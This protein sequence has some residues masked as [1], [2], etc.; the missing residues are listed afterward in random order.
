MRAITTQVTRTPPEADRTRRR[1]RQRTHLRTGEERAAGWLNPDNMSEDCR[2][3]DGKSALQA[4]P[5]L[6]SAAKMGRDGTGEAERSSR[7]RRRST[8]GGGLVEG[9]VESGGTTRVRLDGA[10]GAH[11]DHRVGT[12]Q[13]RLDGAQGAHRAYGGC[14][15]SST[16][17][18]PQASPDARSH[19]CWYTKGERKVRTPAGQERPEARTPDSWYTKKRTQAGQTDNSQPGKCILH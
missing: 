10:Q 17:A 4:P 18:V 15:G 14:M 1:K 8:C 2:W 6:R 16:G 7:R 13:V 11:R 9:G 19:V 12:T 3:V 5:R